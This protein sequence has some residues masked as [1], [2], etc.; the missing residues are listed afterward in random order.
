MA[1]RQL[2]DGGTLGC[3]MGQSTTDLIAFHGGTVTSR[4]AA[5]AL[6]VSLSVFIFTGASILASGTVSNTVASLVDA[7]AEIRNTLRDYNLHKVGA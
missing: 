1:V 2:S 6:S 7:V 4:R 5:A 3:L